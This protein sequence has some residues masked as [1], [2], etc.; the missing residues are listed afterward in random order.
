MFSSSWRN[1]AQAQQMYEHLTLSSIVHDSC[2]IYHVKDEEADHREDDQNL[3]ET[4]LD[5]TE[6]GKGGRERGREGEERGKG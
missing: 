5:S 3:L 1:W 2:Y 6:E 4:I